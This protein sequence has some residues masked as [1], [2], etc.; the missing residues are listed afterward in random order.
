[1]N[2]ILLPGILLVLFFSCNN[3]N[4]KLLSLQHKLDSIELVHKNE[5]V[6]N[7]SET[8]LSELYKTL[9]KGVF[10]L[11]ANNTTNI[12]QGSAFL[13]DNDGSCITCNHNITGMNDFILKDYA[14][15]IVTK[16]KRRV[17]VNEDLDYA[18][19]KIA[20][21][22][23]YTALKIA[24]VKPEIGD[25]CF[26]IGNPRGL[27]Q[28]ISK[29]I[30]SG[31]REGKYIQ[32]DMATTHGSSG[33]P[34]FNR[35]GE[36]IGIISRGIE[37]SGNLNFAVDIN[38]VDL[39]YYSDSEYE[40]LANE[41]STLPEVISKFI[42]AEN[43][44]DFNTVY[45]CFSLPMIRFYRLR[46]PTFEQLYNEYT[47]YWTARPNLQSRI[48]GFESKGNIYDVTISVSNSNNKTLIIRFIL[49]SYQKIQSVTKIN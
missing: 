34:L 14:G 13:L 2:K 18:K 10:V 20:Q 21:N 46:N 36:V 42:Q 5:K 11:Y 44:R 48:T 28:T 25:E 38:Y 27:E 37:G 3:S 1:M 4:E 31:F 35:K 45:S 26:A 41:S 43:Q 9:R 6:I 24:S 17:Y 23:E 12:A 32:I 15:N 49:D 29:G 33:C 30:I 19:F 40:V 16:S 7:K 8:D 22:Y 47:T 39:H